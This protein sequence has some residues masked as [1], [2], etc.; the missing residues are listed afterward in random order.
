MDLE[1]KA[2]F[3]NFLIPDPSLFRYNLGG[4]VSL[5]CVRLSLRTS[6]RIDHV[7]SGISSIECFV[8]PPPQSK[9]QDDLSFCSEAYKP[10]FFSLTVI[11]CGCFL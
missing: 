9:C 6:S 1:E 5:S 11:V 10:Y 7:Y 8:L 4:Y 2:N 3:A